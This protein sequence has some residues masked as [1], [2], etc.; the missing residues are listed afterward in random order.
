M[1]K[2]K[3]ILIICVSFG[4]ILIGIMIFLVFGKRNNKIE[5]IMPVE[6]A[7]DIEEILLEDNKYNNLIIHDFEVDLSNVDKLYNIEIQSNTDY[8]NRT[9]IENFEIMD[10]VIND[11]FNEEFDK[12][13]EYPLLDS[14]YGT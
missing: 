12:S 7:T 10:K 3:T 4:I 5:N 11:F 1:N 2:R 6:K 9:F 14:A 8:Q 13:L